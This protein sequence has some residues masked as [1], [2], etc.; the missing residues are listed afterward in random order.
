M[1][2]KTRQRL[3]LYLLI[4]SIMAFLAFGLIFYM[5]QYSKQQFAEN[6]FDT[7]Y[8]HR[9]YKYSNPSIK[10]QPYY[11]DAKSSITFVAFMDTRSES[12]RD[13]IGKIFPLLKKDY[14]DSGI[15]RFYPKPYIG[16]RDIEERNGNFEASMILECIKKIKKEEYHA[17]YINMLMKNITDGRRIAYSHKIPVAS[18]NECMYSNEALKALYKDALEIES[19]GIVG[20]GQRFYIGVGG[21]DNTLL[22]GVQPYEEFQQ[23]IRQQAIKV[24]G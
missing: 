14:F 18:Y 7:P 11:G 10:D 16:I 24:G 1:R 21:R 4:S 8:A 22:E 17:V 5:V 9:L 19:L 2:K 13:F 20:I 12:S 3:K 6:I 15:A 23:A